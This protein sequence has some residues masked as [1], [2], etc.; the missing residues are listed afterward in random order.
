MTGNYEVQ[1]QII[2]KGM[3]KPENLSS[4]QFYYGNNITSVEPVTGS[5]FG[6]REIQINGSYFSPDPSEN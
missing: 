3:A 2:G 1:V 5:Y 4:M 6:G